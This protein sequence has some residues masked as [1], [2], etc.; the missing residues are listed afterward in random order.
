MFVSILNTK[1][2]RGKDKAY[3]M[4]GL[5]GTRTQPI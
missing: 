1:Q 2:D 3:N 4:E 5:Y